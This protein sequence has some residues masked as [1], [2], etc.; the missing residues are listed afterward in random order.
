MGR[1][2][3]KVAFVTGA[4]RGQGR[5]HAVM[6]AREG[7]AVVATDLCAQ[8]AQV[9]YPMSTRDDLDETARLIEQEGRPSPHPRRGRPGPGKLNA[10]ALAGRESFGE[11]DIV[12]A[13]A[14]IVGGFGN[15]WELDED[16]FAAHLE[17]NLLGVWKTVKA[18]VPG[19]VDRGH[20]GSVILISSIS[21][22]APEIN[23]AHYVA[24]KHGVVGLMRNLA[25]ELAP[26]MIRVNTVNQ[27]TVNTKMVDNPAFNSLFAGRPTQD[28][29]DAIE[30]MMGLQALSIPYLDPS[31]VSHA[32]IYLASDEARYVTGSTLVVDGGALAPFKIPHDASA[33]ESYQAL[34]AR[35]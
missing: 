22:L 18:T 12:V 32:V 4:A 17:T 31:D 3:G 34:V 20:G 2:D 27:T 5:S 16:D 14:G 8:I 11:Y 25:V 30:G 28:Q 35:A 26:H 9:Q 21:G 19:M 29:A 1:L 33:H 13:N 23:I 15:A 24:S 10:A 6:L 7:A